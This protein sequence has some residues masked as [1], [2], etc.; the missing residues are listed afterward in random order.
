MSLLEWGQTVD[1]DEFTAS[2]SSDHLQNLG[3][4]SSHVFHPTTRTVS[5]LYTFASAAVILL[6][7]DKFLQPEPR[8]VEK[9]IF[10]DEQAQIP[11]RI[12]V[13]FEF[14]EHPLRLFDAHPVLHRVVV[15]ERQ[16]PFR[17]LVG[18]HAPLLRMFR[19][20]V[21]PAKIER[22]EPERMD[23]VLV[24]L[25]ELAPTD[26]AS[27]FV[28]PGNPK[29]PMQWFQM[30]ASAV[31][32]RCFVMISVVVALSISFSTRSIPDS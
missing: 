10:A 27:S 13:P 31:N 21:M 4:R 29:K 25:Q 19:H 22:A 14:L 9:D 17:I 6:N 28:S 7:P 16:I 3:L 24:L 20:R 32:C 15:V 30:P 5:L 1:L 12:V 26:Q 23:M 8:D 2:G 18:R 11:A